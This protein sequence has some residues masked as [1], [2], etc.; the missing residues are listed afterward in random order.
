[1]TTPPPRVWCCNQICSGT[2]RYRTSTSGTPKTPPAAA[3]AAIAA[4]VSLTGCSTVQSFSPVLYHGASTRAVTWLATAV[5]P[6]CAVATDC[7]CATVAGG[8]RDSATAAITGASTASTS[9]LAAAHSP[10]RNNAP[11]MAAD[12]AAIMPATAAAPGAGRAADATATA[13][14]TF[15]AATACTSAADGP[16]TTDSTSTSLSPA[17]STSASPLVTILNMAPR[18]SP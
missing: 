11:S 7:R 2:L 18:A 3:D 1:M 14:A 9:P 6:A 10:A 16:A 13:A 4:G 17:A 5:S 12:T 8:G 15:P